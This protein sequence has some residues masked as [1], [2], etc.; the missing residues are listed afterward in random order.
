MLDFEE[1]IELVSQDQLQVFA[2]P[3]FLIALALEYY[4]DKYRDGGLYQKKD[5]GASLG[6]LLITAVSLS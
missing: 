4:W 2:L 5:L 6:M 3:V 1:A